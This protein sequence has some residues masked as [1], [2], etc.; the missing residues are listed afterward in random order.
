MGYEIDLDVVQRT[1]DYYI[2]RSSNGSSL[3]R[4]VNASVLAWLNPDRSWASFQDALV[5]DLDDTQGGT[6][7]EG[8]HLGAMAGSVEIVTRAYAGLRVRGEWLEFSPHLPPQLED[9]SFTV[10]YRGQ[11][12]KVCIDHEVLELEGASRG[13]QPVTIHVAGAEY[14]LKAGQKIAVSIRHRP[15]GR[16]RPAGA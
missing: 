1:V 14:T 3:S 6:T 16:G 2:S 5:T 12:I 15:D 10:L 7:G 9:V 8:I 11:V 13:A 4:V